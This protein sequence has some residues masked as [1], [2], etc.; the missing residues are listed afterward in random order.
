MRRVL[1]RAVARCAA[2]AH[3]DEPVRQQQRLRVGL[4]QPG[5]QHAIGGAD[6]ALEAI[7]APRGVI[8]DLRGHR[9]PQPEGPDEEDGEQQSVRAH[10]HGIVADRPPSRGYGAASASKGDAC[11]TMDVT[12]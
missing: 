7:G 1:A 9:R 11:A 2:V 8:G 4:G 3:A 5:A 12:P 10:V 6:G